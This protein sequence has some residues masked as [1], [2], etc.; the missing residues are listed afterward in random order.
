MNE[1]RESLYSPPWHDVSIIGI[2]GSSGSGKTS[3]AVEVISGLDRP[4]VVILSM[5]HIRTIR[6]RENELDDS[7]DSFYKPL[8][9]AQSAAAFR[10][11]F[12]F[13]SPDAVDFDLLVERLQ[14]I[15]QGKRA[16]IPIYSFE[17]HQRQEKTTTIYSSRVLILEGI[18]AL[19]DPRVME[20]LDMKIF[21]EADADTCLA[22]RSMF[23][24]ELF[25][26]SLIENP[27]LVLR[28]VTSRGRDVEGVVKQWMTFVKP[29]FERYVNPQ[30]KNADIIIPRGIENKVAI[31]MVVKHIQQLLK[32][33]SRKHAAELQKLGQQVEDEPL[34]AH[35]LSLEPS[36]Q[37]RGIET[38]LEDQDSS[39]EDFIFY[40]DRLVTMLVERAMDA[41][42]RF[43]A[44]EVQTP[45][46]TRYQGLQTSGEA[47]LNREQISAVVI[48]RGGSALETGL[49][50]VI[51][52][53]R[54][55]RMLIQTNI[56]T[57]EPELHFRELPS[58]IPSHELVL[59]LDT[60]MSSGGAALMA[61]RVLLD[62]GVAPERIVFV[63]FLAGKV[64]LNRLCKV[65]PEIRVVVGRIGDDYEDRITTFMKTGKGK[66]SLPGSR[67]L[68]GQ[69]CASE[70]LGQSI[71]LPTLWLEAFI[72]PKLKGTLPGLL[73]LRVRVS[74]ST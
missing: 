22:R 50:R 46:G 65:F 35:V 2:A 71:H 14:D 52:D 62:H 66:Q 7:Q 6:R 31:D 29:N 63:T 15:K 41:P 21:A 42:A 28:D 20:L 5:V 34:S 44:L 3:L 27:V 36:P 55:G 1:R 60:Q 23:P 57:G 37:M 43:G 48:L 8:T 64:G 24:I 16:E 74:H 73:A 68:L 4:W 56:R 70:P 10:N 11:E 12:D 54:T 9:P 53:C 45:S 17:Q 13:D 51:P 40:F 30:R 18:F 61:V 19:Y 47:S 39:T 67:H 32:A 72:W 58:N 25:E 69:E 59:L 33:N 49:K 26:K 38:I